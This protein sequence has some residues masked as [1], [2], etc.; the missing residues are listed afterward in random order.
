MTHTKEVL[1]SMYMGANKM[2]EDCTYEEFCAARES[3]WADDD[4]ASDLKLLHA[5]EQA[6]QVTLPNQDLQTIIDDLRQLLL[7]RM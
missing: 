4:V 2:P 7:G 5:Y 6:A 3:I 1:W